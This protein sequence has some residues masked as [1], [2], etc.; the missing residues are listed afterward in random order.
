[1]PLSVR[2]PDILAERSNHGQMRLSMP[3]RDG[4]K[5]RDVVADSGFMGEEA[6][7]ILIVVNGAQVEREASISDGDTIELVIQMVGGAQG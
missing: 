3:Y 5:A 7:A 2:M 6:D 4:M 1:M